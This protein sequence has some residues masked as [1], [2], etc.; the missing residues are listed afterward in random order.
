MKIVVCIKPVNKELV[1][2]NQNDDEP[3]MINPY[4]LYALEQCIELKKR[5]NAVITC[6]CM[7]SQRASSLLTAAIAMGADEGVLVNDPAF[8]GSDT[9][10]TSYILSKA[11]EA[12]GMPDMII[13][14][15]KTIDGETGQVVFGLAKRINFTPFSKVKSLET[16]QDGKVIAIQE[17]ENQMLMVELRTPV[18]C[19][20]SD[21]SL[22][23]S[24]YSL[25]AWKLAKRKDITILTRNE[26]DIDLSRCGLNGSR[27]KVCEIEQKLKRKEPEVI[28]G[29]VKE[30]ARSIIAI[31]MGRGRGQKDE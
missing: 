4:D 15:E 31:I 16:V 3:F 29:S 12:I 30:M 14:G 11:I 13:C 20:F 17:K 1:F 28:E 21:F 24:N 7:G 5:T 27:T 9:V 25:M 19:A 26:L 10:A 22:K 23:Q 8:A 6:L 2:Q 18:L